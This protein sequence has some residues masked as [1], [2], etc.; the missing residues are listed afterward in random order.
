MKPQEDFSIEIDLELGQQRAD[1]ARRLLVNLRDQHDL[2]SWEYTT[3]VR[4]APFE[5]PHSH[6]VL[7]LNARLVE[8]EDAFLATYLHEQIHWALTLHRE[9]E[10]EVAVERLKALYPDAHTA[11]PETAQNEQSTYLH[12]V[13]NYLE[14]M[15]VSEII[16]RE[17]AESQTQ[18]RRVYTW[19]Y[20]AVLDDWDDIETLLEATEVL[21]LPRANEQ[22]SNQ[23]I[24]Q[25]TLQA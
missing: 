4:I 9:E 20:R 22:G 3:K 5:V 8:D 7:T 24:S 19:I 10:T 12:L 25:Y 11:F 1:A 18:R 16:G 23:G 15:V 13:V 2:T 6:P 14:L 21:P 17:R